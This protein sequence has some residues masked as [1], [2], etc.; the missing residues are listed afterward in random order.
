MI[1]VRLFRSVEDWVPVY[2]DKGRRNQNK[3]GR[4]CKMRCPFWTTPS[5]IPKEGITN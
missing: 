4:V 2:P 3:R 1:Y 5:A